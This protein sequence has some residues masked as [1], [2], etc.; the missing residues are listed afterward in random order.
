MWPL[1]M[2]L[3]GTYNYGALNYVEFRAAMHLSRTRLSSGVNH[4]PYMVHGV[5]HAQCAVH[6]IRV[7]GCH[8][9]HVV[10]GG[11]RGIRTLDPVVSGIHDFQSCPFGLS[12]ISP[13]A[14]HLNLLIVRSYRL[15]PRERD[16]L[17]RYARSAFP[18][19]APNPRS[20]C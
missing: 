16:V 13:S 5:V 4:E 12:G 17:A 9:P 7:H 11:E 8:E 1:F 14:K 2:H 20:R 15:S 18:S 6:H 10:R 19:G 3:D